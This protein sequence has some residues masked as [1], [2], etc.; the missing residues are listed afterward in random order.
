MRSEIR[1]RAYKYKTCVTHQ[2]III[3]IIILIDNLMT[4]NLIG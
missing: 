3:Y 4:F 1:T 2:A